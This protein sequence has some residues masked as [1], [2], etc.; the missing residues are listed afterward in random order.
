MIDYKVDFHAWALHNAQLLRQGQ[1]SE[2]DCEHIAEELESTG[3]SQR[4]EIVSR[5]KILL[6]HLLKWAYQFNQITAKWPWEGGSW[7]GTIREQRMRI[8]DLIQDNPSLKPYLP[9]AIRLAYPEA[10]ELASEDT[11]FL[12]STFPEICP[13]T[14]ECIL[15]RQFFPECRD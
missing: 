9:N 10:I 1:L 14:P 12:A 4:Q 6:G 2:I 8:N 15:D 5:L 7:R 13:Y 3:K 11:G